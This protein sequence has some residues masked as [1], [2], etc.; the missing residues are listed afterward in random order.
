MMS[1]SL[2]K[3]R[4]SLTDSSHNNSSVSSA[5]ATEYTLLIN[6]ASGRPCRRE[7]T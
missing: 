3:N 6:A 2:G 5:I 4:F 1:L 7:D